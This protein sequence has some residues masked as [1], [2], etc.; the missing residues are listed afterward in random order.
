MKHITQFFISSLLVLVIINSVRAENYAEPLLENT[1][2]VSTIHRHSIEEYKQQ[3]KEISH[4]ISS[5]IDT[6]SFSEIEIFPILF[7]GNIAEQRQKYRKAHKALI[8]NKSNYLKLRKEVD[9]YP[10]ATYLDYQYLRK[11][12]NSTTFS[13]IKKSFN[14]PFT[15]K[16]ARQLKRDRLKY[17]ARTSDWNKF[18]KK[19]DSALDNQT[20]RCYKARAHYQIGEEAKAIALAKSLWLT[21]KSMPNAC[22]SMF[23]IL[24]STELISS[25]MAWQR[26]SGSFPNNEITLSNYLL[27]FL[28]T[29]QLNAAKKILD[30]YKNPDNLIK[31]WDSLIKVLSSLSSE[32]QLKAIQIHLFKRLA[33]SDRSAAVQLITKKIETPT[34]TGLNAEAYDELLKKIKSYTLTLHALEDYNDLPALYQKLNNPHDDTSLEWLLRSY[35]AKAQWKKLNKLIQSLP[36][37]LRLQDRWQYWHIRS[38]QL[39][40]VL[41][42]EEY[43]ALL[44][45][46]KKANFYGFAAAHALNQPYML[47][48][49]SHKISATALKKLAANMHLQRA[50]EHFVHDDFIP[51]QREWSYAISNFDRQQ[52]LDA[53]YL[54]STIGWHQQ[55][56]H[57]IAQAKAWQ[58]YAIRFPDLYSDQFKRQAF[59]YNQ[60]PEWF[61]AT[62]RQESALS[63]S[64]NSPAGAIGLMQIMPATAKQLA[65]ENNVEYNRTSLLKPDYSIQLGTAYLSDLHMRYNNRALGSAAYNAGPHRVDRWLKN[66]KKALP[67]DAWI[68]T[69]RFSETRQYVQNILSFGLIHSKL[70][71]FNELEPWPTFAFY[72]E[73]ELIIRPYKK[74]VIEYKV[75]K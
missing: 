62:A 45:I 18:L 10:L 67:I 43:Q 30:L 55:A 2:V 41:S 23:H 1:S 20:L 32:D 33:R 12:I 5:N 9:Q 63:S 22:D 37:S 4:S 68:E 58:H 17:L 3:S 48:P 15:S 6:Y 8:D 16:Y 46:S 51:A 44:N 40:T 60:M 47:E 7:A 27:R 65:R 36:D 28:E 25:D 35:I 31:N 73:E 52:L 14:T 11:N 38:K 64:A 50:I 49:K 72:S 57:T 13:T 21:P 61:Y 75:A 54:A 66:L 74:Q 34:T 26:F 39:T 29:E 59:R 19:Y 70:Y 42:D 53:A 24:T 69:I 71:T 56:I